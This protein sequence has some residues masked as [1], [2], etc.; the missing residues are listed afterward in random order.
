MLRQ[1]RR[2]WEDYGRRDPFFGVLSDPAKHGGRWSR[3]E[4]FASGVAHIESLMRSLGDARV[5]VPRGACLDFGC[6][7]GRLTQAL[8]RYF[9]RVTGVDVAASM[10]RR[11]RAFNQHG[12]RCTYVVNQT[13]D[14]AQFGDASFA[15][16]HSCIVLQHMAPDLASAYLREF[17]RVV[18]P[19]GLVVFQL[20][21]APRRADESPA[22]FA[23]PD[24]D[25]RATLTLAGACA[26]VRRRHTRH[27]LG[28]RAERGPIGLAGDDPDRA[29]GSHRARQPLAR[30]RRQRP[31]AR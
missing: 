24:Q 17:F 12:D 3:E 5:A 8:C 31:R 7:V 25:Y 1:L 29:C 19:G 10:I 15:V 11:A 9:D 2:T 16:V 22:A 13:A 30:P 21:S 23:L 6:G 4:F 14:L 20:P 26:G 18:A 27:R 28:P